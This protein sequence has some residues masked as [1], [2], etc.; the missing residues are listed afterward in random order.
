MSQEFLPKIL[1]GKARE[2][3]AM[4]EEK[5]QPLRET[6]RLYDYPKSHQ[7]S[8]LDHCRGEVSNWEIFMSMDIVA[9]AKM[10]RRKWGRD[11]FASGLMKCFLLA[12]SSISP[13]NSQV[14]IPTSNK[15]FLAVD[16]KQI[17]GANAKQPW[18]CWLLQPY[19]RLVWK[20][21]WASLRPILAWGLGGDP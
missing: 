16:E 15:D 11:D 1:K 8:F 7:E 14:R 10:R 17:P 18:S 5:L 3:A 19:Q 20:A 9:Q 21:F 12:V 2:V 6:Y 4:K 13:R